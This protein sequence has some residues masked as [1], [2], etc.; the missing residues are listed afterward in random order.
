VALSAE[1]SLQ[2]WKLIEPWDEH[3]A[4][5]DNGR[6][7]TILLRM[8]F[9]KSLFDYT[10]RE[11]TAA[12]ERMVAPQT[13]VSIAPSAATIVKE[14]TPSKSVPEIVQVDPKDASPDIDL[15]MVAKIMALVSKGMSTGTKAP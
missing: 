8:F 11:Q 7:K 15:A 6:G 14:K 1:D 13:H 5:L 12:R 9:G 3:G 10:A 2:K 4:H